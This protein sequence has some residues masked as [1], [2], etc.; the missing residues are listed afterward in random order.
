MSVLHLL[1]A[2]ALVLHLPAADLRREESRR[3]ASS[4]SNSRS[5]SSRTDGSGSDIFV[6]TDGGEATT[7]PPIS[8][9]TEVNPTTTIDLMLFCSMELFDYI[10]PFCQFVVQD[11]TCLPAFSNT[12]CESCINIVNS[13]GITDSSIC[14]SSLVSTCPQTETFLMEYCTIV[15]GVCSGIIINDH[16]NASGSGDVVVPSGSG[17]PEDRSRTDEGS[18]SHSDSIAFTTASPTVTTMPTPSGS[19]SSPVSMNTPL[20]PYKQLYPHYTIY[21][22]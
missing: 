16:V 17:D 18:R 9:T 8:P 20:Q 21:Y 10:G 3:S 11:G 12:T 7:L 14:D 4:S 15:D 19:V 2:T 13:C 5:K 22:S 1:L 6:T